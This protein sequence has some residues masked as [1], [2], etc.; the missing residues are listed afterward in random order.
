MT[1]LPPEDHEPNKRRRGRRRK[2]KPAPVFEIINA[3]TKREFRLIEKERLTIP[4]D[5]YQRDES[6]GRIATEIAMHYDVVAF[7]ALGV[8]ERANG[9]LVVMDGGTR[10]SG[11]LQRD[12]ILVVPCLVF[13]G[14][15]PQQEADVFLRI[16]LNRRRLRTLQQHHAEL[17]S[18][19]ELAIIAQQYTDYLRDG[20]VGWDGMTTMRSAVK[21]D[22]SAIDAV[23]RL[24][25]RVARDKHVTTKVMKG[26]V[27]LERLL[28]KE[29]KSLDSRPVLKKLE[30]NFGKLDAVVNAVC[31]P[32]RQGDPNIFARALART[33]HIKVPKGEA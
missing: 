15:T 24:L 29:D 32:R 28:Q 14:L 10:L 20:R 16:N 19:K 21:R 2:E 17:F 23:V 27:R 18:E 26:L 3:H 33:L 22:L 30:A 9:E 11:S 31:E 8:I 12:D 25:P 13:S 5:E 7:Q 6:T 4:T 1:L